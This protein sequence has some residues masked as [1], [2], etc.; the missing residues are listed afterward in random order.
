MNL[1][2]SDFQKSLLNSTTV[3]IWSV[4]FKMMI[5]SM[6]LYNYWLLMTL[7]SWFVNPGDLI[8]N[9]AKGNIA[10]GLSQ[11]ETRDLEAFNKIGYC[12]LTLLLIL[13]LFLSN[14]VL[15]HLEKMQLS[16]GDLRMLECLSQCCS[17]LMEFMKQ[18]LVCLTFFM[19]QNTG[20]DIVL[21]MFVNCK[22]MLFRWGMLQIF[23]YGAF[24]NVFA[25]ELYI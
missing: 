10:H 25:Y 4:I 23:S 11:S 19:K 2:N 15:K 6:I 7:T 20:I 22:E 16:V 9:E 17:M 12:L 1:N 18:K 21:L 5:T 3:Y 14:K 24:V 13:H 8:F